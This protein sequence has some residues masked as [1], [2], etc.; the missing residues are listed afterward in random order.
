MPARL[1]A[2]RWR[3][4]IPH[5]DRALEVPEAERSAWLSS[6]AAEDARLAADIAALL[7]KH[8]LLE[9]QGFLAS[10]VAMVPPRR[11]LA[12]Q[13]CGAYTLRSPLGQ[14][15]M[16]S[17]WLADRSDGR[18]QGVVAV[19]M[20]NASLLGHDAEARFRREGS[21]LAR[22]RHPHI[23]HL[24]DAGVS[25]HG[26]PYLALEHVDGERID[27]YCD[28]HRLGIEARVR[29]FLDVLAAVSHAHANLVVHRDLKPSN[30]LVGSDGRVKLLDFGIAKLLESDAAEPVTALTRDGES[31]L[32]PEYAA[33]EQL[34]GGAV[35]T[36]T[37][38]YALGALLYL[39]LAGR[40]PASEEAQSPADLVRAIVD[41]DARRLS[42]AAALDDQAD[43][44]AAAP[45]RRRGGSGR[46]CGATSRTS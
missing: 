40:H 18:F 45:P 42:D 39:L 2:D 15:G 16:G 36:A 31:M 25:D 9:E 24:I 44:R 11:T 30:V 22:L 27:R 17:V 29:L 43:E 38:V 21:I 6:V 12:G 5:L 37:D 33:P 19:K 13:A 28:A 46:R 10:P 8:D 4:L 20:L 1:S 23:A 3:V 7:E 41:T 34:T 26:Q 35:T 32:T 14:G